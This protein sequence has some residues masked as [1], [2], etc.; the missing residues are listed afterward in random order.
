MSSITTTDRETFALTNPLALLHPDRLETM[1]WMAG[2]TLINLG[3][4]AGFWYGLPD[5]QVGEALSTR[6]E[7]LATYALVPGA[8]VLATVC[9]CMRLFDTVHAMDP[10]TQSESTFYRINNRV[11]TNTV[12]QAL[13]FL[14]VLLALGLLLD[15][16]LFR[17]LPVLTAVWGV[18]RAIF[19]VAYQ[20]HAP[21][22]S[23]GMVP[24]LT[25]SVVA[26]GLV[27]Y[28]LFA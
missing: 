7:H 18:S 10:L 26:Y 9:S 4:A 22:R 28:T 13:I 27:A 14:P 6:L 24:T 21:A 12:E 19:W 5:P 11:L 15:P 20:L 1:G 2:G 23:L 25:T 17:V 3:L 8:A 16:S